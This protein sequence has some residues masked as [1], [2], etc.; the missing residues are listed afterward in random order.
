M[1]SPNPGCVSPPLDGVSTIGGGS[2]PG[3]TLPTWLV[4]I[5]HPSRSANSLNNG[6]ARRRAD[7]RPHRKGPSRARS[8][9]RGSARRRTDRVSVRSSPDTERGIAAALSVG[10][11]HC[12]RWL[13]FRRLVTMNHYRVMAA[14]V[15]AVAALCTCTRPALAQHAEGSLPHDFDEPI[16][17]YKTVLGTFKRPISSSNAEAQAYF[18]QGFQLM[19]AFARAEA[20]RSFR[21]AEKRDPDLCDLLLGRSL[22]MGTVHQRRPNARARDPRLRRDSEGARACRA[23]TRRPKRKPSSTR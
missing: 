3:A 6:F 10:A 5:D 13:A 23:H 22:G 12:G 19:Y 17:L 15:L 7:H 20:G 9:H 2:A 18:N 21:E 1:H 8:A 14:S 4:A 16:G 11:W